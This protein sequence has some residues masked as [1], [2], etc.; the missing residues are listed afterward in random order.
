MNNVFIQKNKNFNKAQ[1]KLN[2][3]IITPN[4]SEIESEILSQYQK[5]INQ[6]NQTNKLNKIFFILM[7][8]H[9]NKN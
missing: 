9:T 7:W 4:Q 8:N 2:T 1:I 5:F 6:F 3:D